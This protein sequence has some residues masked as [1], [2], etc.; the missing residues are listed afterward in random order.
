MTGAT[1]VVTRENSP[2]APENQSISIVTTELAAAFHLTDQD[3]GED[4]YAIRVKDSNLSLL[5]GG[6][7]DVISTVHALRR[8]L[9][10]CSQTDEDDPHLRRD[11]ELRG[12][13]VQAAQ[14]GTEMTR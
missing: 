1:F 6:E 9:L 4:G 2:D 14:D 12:V 5:G 7:K 13:R 3:L 11:S 8:E 10:G